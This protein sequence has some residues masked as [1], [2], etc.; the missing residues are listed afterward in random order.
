[1]NPFVAGLAP[2]LHLVITTSPLEDLTSVILFGVPVDTISTS[3]NSMD[4]EA[5]PV[6]S[7]KISSS[8]PTVIPDIHLNL[9]V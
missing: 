1:M 2:K 5:A 3:S 4:L 9:T 8:A 6:T 7:N